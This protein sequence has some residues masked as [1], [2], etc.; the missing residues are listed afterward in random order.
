MNDALYHQLIKDLARADHGHG[1]L[2]IADQAIRLD[3]PLCGDRI[4]LELTVSAGRV[5]ALG[6]ITRGCMLCRAAASLLALRAPGSELAE[7]VAAA[8][9]LQRMLR[10]EQE[11]PPATIWPDFEAFL[12]V[13]QHRSRHGCVLLPFQALEALAQH[14]ITSGSGR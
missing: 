14:G 6:Q 12:P 1:H 13:R 4:D 5:T 9:A 2:D 11:Q 8:Q 10:G 7:V 3:N